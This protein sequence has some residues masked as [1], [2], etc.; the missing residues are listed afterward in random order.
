MG[1]TTV[2]SDLSPVSPGFIEL[3]EKTGVTSL[4]G[5]P[6]T[7]QL[8]DRLQIF[9]RVPKSVKYF[10]QAGGALPS[11]KVAN[12]S[13]KLRQK[14]V[15][16]HPM[17]G[18]TEATARIS[19]MPSELS[20]EFPNSVGRVLPSGQ[21]SVGTEN[22]PSELTYFGPN[23]ML[24]YSMNRRDLLRDDEN[25]GVLETGDL[26]VIDNQ[27]LIFI[28]GRIKRIAKINGVRI[29]LQEIEKMLGLETQVA[30]YEEENRLVIFT[31]LQPVEFEKIRI[32][33]DKF[34]IQKRDFTI[35]HTESIPRL[36]SG[37]IDYE[38]LRRI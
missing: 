34:G 5:V 26:A 32:S 18:Q 4:V 23:T 6:F 11:E 14:G 22:H 21:I 1:G 12:V 24:G 29:N 25:A 19:V 8:Y 37:K 7:Y 35:R 31:E 17:Y 28:E 13:R 36:S 2:C 15:S 33:L 9:D 38:E 16:F 27:G 3:I 10:T 30:I 20:L